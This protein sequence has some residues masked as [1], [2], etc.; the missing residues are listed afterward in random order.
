MV[1]TMSIPPERLY[2]PDVSII[3]WRKM[4]ERPR[5]TSPELRESHE[6]EVEALDPAGSRS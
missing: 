6:S 4:C 2:R 3:A 5:G 1:E